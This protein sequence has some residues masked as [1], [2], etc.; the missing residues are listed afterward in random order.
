MTKHILYLTISLLSCSLAAI[1]QQPQVSNLR[2]R[3]VNTKSSPQ[4]LDT[5]SIAPNTFVADGVSPE[6]YDLDEVNARITWKTTQ[7]PDSVFVHFRVFPF[8]LN[9]VRRHMNYDSIRYNFLAEEAVKKRTGDN[10]ANPFINFGGVEAEGSFGRSLSFG[11]SQ[12]AV[13]NSTMNLQ[14]HGYIGDSLE[15]T[16]AITDNNIPIQPE[17]NTQDLRDFDRIY[18]QV[19]KKSW[20]A[21]F[22]D[23]DIRESKTYFLKFYKR[24]QGISFLS[25]NRLGKNISSSLLASGAIAKGKFTRNIL[26]PLE[27]NQGPYRLTGASNELYFIVLAGTERVFMDGELLQRGEENDY[28]INYNTAE[29]TFTPKRPVNKDKR[30][31]VEFEYADRNYLNSQFYV[32][33]EINYKNKL[34]VNAGVYS[35]TDAKNSTIDQSL[36]IKQKQ[37]LSDIGDSVQLGY[38]QNAIRDSFSLGK[39]LYR[40]TDTLVNFFHD[41]VFVQSSSPTDIL[42]NL[43]F[44]YLGTGKG[45]YRQLLNGSNGKVFQWV[46]PV[47]GIPQGDWEPVSLLVTPKQLQVF[48]LA[49]EYLINPKTSFKAEGALSNYDVNLFS[50]KDKTNDVGYAGRVGLVKEFKR[51]IGSRQWYNFTLSLGHEYVQKQFK[52]LE[53]LRNVEFLRDWSLPYDIA[54]A[55]ENISQASI[56]VFDSSTNRLLYNFTRYNRS[57]GYTGLRH[58]AEQYT[59]WKKLIL[60][61]RVSYTTIN[62]SFQSGSFLRPTLEVKKT[63]PFLRLVEGGFKYTGEYNRLLL[64]QYDTLSPLSFA[65]NKYEVFINSNPALPNKY[66][67]SWYYRND[68]LPQ[69]NQL[70]AADES[71]NYNVFTELL[72]NEKHQVKLTATYRRLTILNSGLSRQRPDD[73]L[74]GRVEYYINEWKG[75]LNGN[76][77][78]E[79]GSGQEQKR[80]YTYIEVPAGQGAYTWND[81]NMNGI[82]EL[83]EFELA[84]YPDQKKYIRIFTPG[85][86]YVKANY[87]QFNYSLVLDPKALMA[88][89]PSGKLKKIFYRSSTSSALQVSNKQLANGDFLF[90]PFARKLADTTLLTLNSFLSNTYFYNRSSPRWGLEL[91]HTLNAGKA[92]LA[93]GIESRRLSGLVNKLRVNFNRSLVSSYV[94]R[95]GRNSLATT[96][97]KFENRNYNINIFAAEPTLTY[98]YKSNL[99]ASLGYAY[100]Q[101]QNE[102]DSLEKSVIHSLIS[103]IKYSRLS[104]GSITGRFTL[105]QTNFFAYPGAANS[106]VGYIL[107]D[108]LLPGKNYLW[109]LEYTRRLGG[110][111]EL[112]LQY[113]G[114]KP[115]NTRTIHTG[116][117]SV[118]AIF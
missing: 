53:R 7:I 79:I 15:L 21:N 73:N 104:S 118:R 70:K 71:Q 39:I 66:G 72:K 90:N 19:K 58:V 78:Y 20:Q 56:S 45:N 99:R 105:N 30:I 22:G 84:L 3:W 31:Q 38:Y 48:T 62:S 82:P 98:T 110:N 54:A 9:A 112:T 87:L 86:Q 28:I 69:G 17:G 64:K 59:S 8:R 77:L 32:S 93:Y 116:R 103:E 111:L 16:A 26:T 83:N 113:D 96:G 33:E 46:A 6:F 4:A 44:T 107:L 52:P 24:L 117:A 102:I 51:K 97:D 67:I 11:N 60:S 57:D 12:D 36:D 114:R 106:T 25:D 68:L 55:D 95:T 35:G 29:V 43:G 50:A 2:A 88:T 63:F 100:T 27:G 37:F 47:A 101:K 40:K 10:A 18:M 76:V 74:L 115:G 108:G 34:L 80:E 42:Y 65:F 85:S 89:E 92:L 5:F 14:L 13:V 75:F 41:S 49:A 23:I 109:N 81:Y 94:I 61:N 91:T 1:A